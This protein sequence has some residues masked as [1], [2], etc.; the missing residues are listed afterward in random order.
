MFLHWT[1]LLNFVLSSNI[2]RIPLRINREAKYT[3]C[4]W[5]CFRVFCGVMF[6]PAFLKKTKKKTTFPSFILCHTNASLNISFKYPTFFFFIMIIYSILFCTNS[7]V[8]SDITDLDFS[9]YL[10][11]IRGLSV[12]IILLIM[13]DMKIKRILIKFFVK[14]KNRIY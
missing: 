9:F 11:Q 6:W 13:P 1:C 10:L 7:F 2:I 12:I 5:F 4:F 3:K 14:K 8:C